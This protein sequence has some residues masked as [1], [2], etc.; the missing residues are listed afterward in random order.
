MKT[1]PMSTPLLADGGV[2]NRAPGGLA[3]PTPKMP[4][5]QAP[6]TVR[7]EARP[8]HVGPIVS[9]VP[10]RT[11]NHAVKVPAGSYVLPAAHVAS[12]GSGNSMAGL[13]IAS[14]MFSGPYG[15]PAPKMGGGH[16]M[17][18]HAPK[19]ATFSD[20]GAR[21]SMAHEHEMVP[22]NLSGGEFVIPPASII[23]RFGSLENGHKILDK[24]VM[25]ERKKEIELQKRLPPP[26]KE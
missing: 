12:M 24:W 10:G 7:N 5:G 20:G 26:A 18:P 19:A 13:S 1:N 2:A 4:T 17:M 6:W 25:H 15:T 3:F 11:D 8:V 16:G 22:V 23:H 14:K 9:A 21:G